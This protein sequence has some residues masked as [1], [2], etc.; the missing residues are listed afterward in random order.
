M[1]REKR[2][3]KLV[4]KKPARVKKKIRKQR[5]LNHPELWG[6]GLVAAGF[7]L[8]AVLYAG[9]HG[10]FVGHAFARGMH[11]LVGGASWVLPLVFVAFGFLMVVRSAL[12]DVRPFRAGIAVLAF[13]LLLT[14]GKDQGGYF[15]QAVGGAVGIAIGATGSLLLGILLMLVGA[16]L[17]S[18]SSL[19]AILR[20]TGH[21]LHTAP[22]PPPH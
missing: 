2:K 7:F 10:G 3:S 13:G 8:D 21:Q 12:I 9:W 15:G 22:N 20:G 18:G 19:G 6:L 4:P 1:P 16:L 11:A 5:N 14:L 17:L